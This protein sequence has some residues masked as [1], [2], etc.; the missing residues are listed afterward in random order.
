MVHFLFIEEAESFRHKSK[1]S[2]DKSPKRARFRYKVFGDP[3]SEALFRRDVLSESCRNGLIYTKDNSNALNY[4]SWTSL[5]KG[6]IGRICR[7]NK[8]SW[9]I[10]T[11]ELDRFN[12]MQLHPDV[13]KQLATQLAGQFYGMQE[14]PI[15]NVKDNIDDEPDV[16]EFDSDDDESSPEAPF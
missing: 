4:Y 16:E 14:K 6:V 11:S 9:Y 1:D 15:N 8:G 13:A 2:Q 10:D 5:P 7:T 3:A 12:A